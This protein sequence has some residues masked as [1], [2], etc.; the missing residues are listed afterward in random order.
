VEIH[1]PL[2]FVAYRM[3]L[4]SRCWFFLEKSV[5]LKSI[6]FAKPSRA[7][8]STSPWLLGVLVLVAICLPPMFR[9][10]QVYKMVIEFII[11]N[12]ADFSSISHFK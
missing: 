7:A 3:T 6:S 2:D 12:F 5:V 9:Y 10:F 1:E 11:V 8:E 4:K